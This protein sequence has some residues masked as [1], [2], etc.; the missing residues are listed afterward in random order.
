VSHYNGSVPETPRKTSWRDRSACHGEDPDLFAPE[1]TTGRWVQV[2]ADA[3]AVCD[4]CTVRPDCLAWAL[5]TRQDHGIYGGLTEDERRLQL[6]RTARDT[7]K[8][9]GPQL[10]HPTSLQE[11]LDRHTTLQPGG[12]LLWTGAKTPDFRRR[13]L[14]PNQVAFIVDRGYE[15]NGAV[16][17]LCDVKGCVQPSHLADTQERRQRAAATEK[18]SA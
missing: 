3:K 5:E 12:H 2:I 8:P 10:P 6:R 17:R 9:R 15:P 13:Q 7:R 4:R 14:T 1:G 11:L 16:H 18:A